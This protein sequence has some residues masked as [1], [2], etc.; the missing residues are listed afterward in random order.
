[1]PSLP[2]TSS[3]PAATDTP[4][5]RPPSRWLALDFLRVVAVTLMVEG[6]AF[7]ALLGMP[8]RTAAWFQRHT[9][10]HGFTAPMFF[11]SSGLAFG[12]ATFRKWH[13]HLVWG[14]A[15]KTRFARYAWLLFIGY[16][17]HL[18]GL[19]LPRLWRSHSEAAWF[20]FT[21][22]DALHH[23]AV[24]LAF[25]QLLVALTRKKAIFVTLVAIFG[26]L[27]VFSGPWAWRQ[28][29]NPDLPLWLSAYLNVHT[30]SIFP[31]V[32]WSGFIFV[33]V[34]IA[35]W[36]CHGPDSTPDARRGAWL[37]LPAVAALVF[38]HFVGQRGYEL[39]GPH[40]FWK[41]SPIFFL[42]RV[43]YVQ[44]LLSLLCLADLRSARA[45]RSPAE[46]GR[47]PKGRLAERFALGLRVIGQQTLVIYI[48]HLLLLYGFPAFSG[49]NVRWGRS[50]SLGASIL[51]FLV[52]MAASVA[53]AFGWNRLKTGN[54]PWF[55]KARYATAAA[56]V[57]FAL[58]NG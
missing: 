35:R 44:G 27:S 1:M 32:P 46:Q 42:T 8:L 4:T 9:Y 48:V 16:L 41:T 57:V 52:L 31:I 24:V 2:P 53:V 18:P 43:A 28:P 10:V 15:V 38:T 39:F 55:D 30:G 51:A 54:Y 47:S 25:L 13:A 7:T 37:L 45:E 56:I 12:V 11:F 19:S 20:E 23:I 3:L 36:I 14:T 58:L 6:H 5:P 22:V 26:A 33:G 17:L 29:F 34:L 50:L 40:D 49:F 21:R